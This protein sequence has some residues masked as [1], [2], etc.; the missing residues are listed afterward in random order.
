MIKALVVEDCPL[1]MELMEGLL[2]AYGTM[3]FKAENVVEAGRLLEKH[4]PDIVFLDIQLPGTD[5]ATYARKLRREKGTGLPLL[6]AVTAQAMK[7]DPERILASG[8]DYYLSKPIDFQHFSHLMRLVG[9]KEQVNDE[10][11]EEV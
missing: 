2:E 7:G 8:F 5:G 6:V 3:I 11:W 9:G 10:A 4:K 1:N